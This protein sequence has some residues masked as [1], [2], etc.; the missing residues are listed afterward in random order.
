[1]SSWKRT[2]ECGLVDE[3]LLSKEVVLNG[4]VAKR[5]DHGG[6]IFVDLRDRTCIMQ[7]V[8]NPEF[9]QE[10]HTNAQ[11]LRSE[12]II[13]VKGTVVKRAPDAVNEKMQT[14]K[15]ELQATSLDRKSTRLNSSH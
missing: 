7:V 6:L 1:M 11:A 8:F 12:F 15:L 14:G 9:S 2:V 5:R 3:S 10:A 13:S 4:W